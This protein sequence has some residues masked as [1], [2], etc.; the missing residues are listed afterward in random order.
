VA[1]AAAALSLLAA[2]QQDGIGQDEAVRRIR[3]D[4]EI[5]TAS[6]VAAGGRIT[7]STSSSL[8]GRTL[9]NGVLRFGLETGRFAAIAAGANHPILIDGV[10]EWDPD[11]VLYQ[12]LQP[13]PDGALL[14]HYDMSELLTRRAQATGVH[15][16]TSVLLGVAAVLLAVGWLVWIGRSRAVRRNR[17]FAL[18]TEL[19]QEH[20]ARLEATNRQLESERTRAEQALALAEEKNRV[21]AEF[22][23]MINHELRTPLTAVVT[24]A[25]LL[26]LDPDLPEEERSAVLDAMVADGRR[27]ERMIAQMLTVARI[28]N[29]GLNFELEVTS[30]ESICDDVT[31]NHPRVADASHEAHHTDA[32]VFTDPA[33]LSQLLESLADNAYTHGAKRVIVEC[34]DELPFFPMIEVGTRP[35]APMFF[36]IV[37]DGPGIDL[38]FLPHIFEKFEKRSFSS[39]TGL[40]LYM[41]RMIVEALGGSIAVSSS[42][43]GTT[44]A[45]AVPTVSAPAVAEVSS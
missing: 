27:L 18:E 29:R 22:V 7:T 9:S 30:A 41:A 3:N 33:A 12:V 8:V 14:L 28:E 24:G 10:V 38:N 6:V 19:L 17:E 45:I 13:M 26:R 36:L 42:P 32:L 31:A 5:E 37:D 40:G 4:L 35:L 21:R 43:A 1:D 23:L 20:S 39:G 11:A 34:I 15:T 2:L 44:M 16:L 25:D